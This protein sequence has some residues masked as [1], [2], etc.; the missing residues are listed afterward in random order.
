MI[1]ASF[2]AGPFILACHSGKYDVV[3]GAECPPVGLRVEI[4]CAEE[5]YQF[6]AVCERKR[7]RM[8]SYH[9]SSNSLRRSVVDRM[10]TINLIHE[11]IIVA[12]T[13]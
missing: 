8:L 12:L 13:S 7:Y 9:T 2:L 1:K 11:C 3:H 10:A 6:G 5:S 4:V